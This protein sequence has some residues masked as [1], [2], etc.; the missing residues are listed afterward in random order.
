MDQAQ[1]ALVTG[2]SGGIGSDLVRALSA[3]GVHVL[4][5]YHQRAAEADA[6]VAECTAAGG[7]VQARQLDLADADAIG[8]FLDSTA[9]ILGQ[10]NI[11]VHAAAAA[12]FGPIKSLASSKRDDYLHAFATNTHSLT[13]LLAHCA[14][15]MADNGR[16]VNISSLNAAVGLFG[17]AAY[18]GSKAA[19]EAIIRTA[20]RELGSRGITANTV[21]LGL[22][23]T[24]AMH[25]AVNEAAVNWYKLQSP[26]GRIGQPGDVAALVDFL[27]GEQAGWMTGQTL[28]LDGGYHL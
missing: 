8:E 4:F 9:E 21:Q 12:P 11:L 19:S 10:L 6:L 20:S 2:G 27:V 3:S 24:E 14:T 17:S 26:T 5:T 25:A 7:T 1:T 16:I 13:L 28:R 23:D 18:S 15:A 22:V